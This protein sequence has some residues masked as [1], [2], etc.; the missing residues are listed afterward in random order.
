MTNSVVIA[1]L[2]ELPDGTIQ[3]EVN[4]SVYTSGDL[5]A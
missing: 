3:A 1:F 4:T 5:V 2:V